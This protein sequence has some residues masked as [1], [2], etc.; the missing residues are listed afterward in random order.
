MNSA[1]STPESPGRPNAVPHPN[2]AIA[3]GVRALAPAFWL[4]GINMR[5]LWASAIRKRQQAGALQTLRDPRRLTAYES[6][7]EIHGRLWKPT[8]HTATA[9]AACIASPEPRDSVW[10]AGACPRFLALTRRARCRA[11][12]WTRNRAQNSHPHA[13]DYSVTDNEHTPKAPASGRTPYAFA[14]HGVC[15]CCLRLRGAADNY[16]KRH[17]YKLDPLPPW[18]CDEHLGP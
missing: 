6:P 18:L 10:S 13:T 12:H 5:G 3:H 14:I 8:E 2:H 15:Q 11:L 17:R 9:P 1:P 16:R 7:R 4:R